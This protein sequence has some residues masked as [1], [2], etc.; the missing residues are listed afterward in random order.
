[1]I[2]KDILKWFIELPKIITEFGSWLFEPLKNFDGEIIEFFD[3]TF[4]PIG[5]I[6][7]GA[8]SLILIAK[9]IALAIPG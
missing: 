1:M 8:L 6:S 5:I 3:I 4:T 2:A 7:V 9:I